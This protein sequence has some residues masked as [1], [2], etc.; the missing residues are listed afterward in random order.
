M[1]IKSLLALVV[2]ALLVPALVL[3]LSGCNDGSSQPS[4]TPDPIV[5]DTTEPA[6]EESIDVVPD[7]EESASTVEE[8][9]VEETEPS[10]SV[11][12]EPSTEPLAEEPAEQPVLSWARDAGGLNHCDRLSIYADGRVEAVVCRA[13]AVEPTVYGNLTDEQLVQVLAWAAEYVAFSRRESEM[14]GAVRTTMLHGS[15]EG[16]PALEVKVEIA[17]LAADIFLGMTEPQ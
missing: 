5:A 13:T 15:G 2:L 8:P 6:A 14:S 12:A 17:A 7:A 16:V 3:S 4:S 11:D 1:S 9:V 10:D